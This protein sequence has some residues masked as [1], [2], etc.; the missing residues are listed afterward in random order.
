MG[1]PPRGPSRPAC[2]GLWG[3]AS[4]AEALTIGEGATADRGPEA[5]L[6][7]R[8]LGLEH[9]PRAWP[10]H[11]EV[12]VDAPWHTSKKVAMRPW[13]PDRR[14]SGR[15]R[16]GARLGQVVTGVNNREVCP[17]GEGGSAGLVGRREEEAGGLSDR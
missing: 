6:P 11:M 2:G 5:P 7:A 4:T 10:V 15:E 17:L 12:H 1:T 16:W 13:R 14:G 8:G 3:Q 9:Q